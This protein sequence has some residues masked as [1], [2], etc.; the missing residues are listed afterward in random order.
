MAEQDKEQGK[1]L[2]NV[3]VLDLLSATEESVAGIN[4]VDNVGVVLYSRENAGLLTRLSIGNMGTSIE[5][6]T[7]AKL[8]RG[9]TVIDREYFKQQTASLSLVVLGQLVI[10]PDVPAEEIESGLGELVVAGQLICPEHLMGIVQSK[11]RDL[12]GQTVSYAQAS[13]LTLG[14]LTLDEYALRAQSDG[15]ELVIVGNLKVPNV[16]P[17]DLLEQKI[18]RIQVLGRIVCH[19]ENAQTLLSR[20]DDRTGSTSMTIVPAGFELVE[21]P[22][23]LDADLLGALPVRKLYCTDRV[24]VDQ[25]VDAEALGVGLEALVAKD[26]VVCPEVL[27]S[28]L[29]RKCNVLETQA[30]FYE[31]ELWLV[32]DELTLTPSRF[33]HMDGEATLIV[34]GEVTV[35]PD[36]APAMLGERLVKVHNF[37]RICCT[38]EQMGAIQARLGVSEGE[39]VDSTLVEEAD[40]EADEE[41]D[42]EADEGADVMVGNVGY[43]KL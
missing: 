28:V 43:L 21:R 37:G 11:I 39:L 30:V 25:S 29:Y 12:S 23:V 33:D 14:D 7:G 31:G 42:G 40:G 41:A 18:Q 36:V 9:Q 1:V 6:P 26:I 27:K 17:T 15:T 19:E 4:Q 22:L 5:A 13:R 32:D 34:F 20:M 2:G 24:Q 16:L 38:P 35:A 8:L 10:H 3:G